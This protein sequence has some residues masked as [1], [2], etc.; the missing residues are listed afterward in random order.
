MQHSLYALKSGL[1]RYLCMPAVSFGGILMLHRVDYPNPQGIRCNQHLKMSPESFEDLVK[2]A[3]S[4]RCSF[5]SMDEI[6]D[7]IV[8]KKRAKNVIAITLDDGYKDNFINGFPCFKSLNV[9]FCIYVCT[10]MVEGTLFSWWD[11]LENLVLQNEKLVLHDG[12]EFA[13]TTNEEKNNAFMK[14]RERILQ[15]PQNDLENEV[16]QLLPSYEINSEASCGLT[17]DDIRLLSKESLA[18]IGNH[19]Y[20]HI[21]MK[22]CDVA[23]VTEDIMKA[24]QQMLS[25]VGIQMK[26]FAFPFGGKNAITARD[27]QLVKELGFR[28]SATTQYSVLRYGHNC[29]ELPRIFVT[30]SSYKDAIDNIVNSCKI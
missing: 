13:C 28:T 30:E 26:H 22:A 23:T 5:V 2:Y 12:Q 4:K 19:T 27:I 6:H 8:R 7:I 9:P 24:Q 29:L 20:S 25:K 17:W 16:H 10:K 11:Y 14:I 15:L 3:R 18:T 1:A 21:A